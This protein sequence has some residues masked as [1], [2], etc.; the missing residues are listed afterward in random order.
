V[1]HNGSHGIEISVTSA[2]ITI[3]HGFLLVNNVIT[4]NSGYA[5]YF[6]GSGITDVMLAAAGLQDRSNLHYNNSSGYC[7]LAASYAVGTV[8]AD[9]AFV[10]APNGDF[11]LG[12]SSP[13]I[14]AGFPSA[15]GWTVSSDPLVD[16]G[17]MQ[18]ASSGGG[19]ASGPG[20][21]IFDDCLWCKRGIAPKI[22]A[23]VDAADAIV[24]VVGR[25]ICT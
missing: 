22:K 6:S 11:T 15:I 17:A 23:T 12:A 13:A 9:P 18:R 7:N 21:V 5:V 10:D 25:I 16:I 19:G 1:Y 20:Q 2:N 4:E 24:V 8:N 3:L 14:D